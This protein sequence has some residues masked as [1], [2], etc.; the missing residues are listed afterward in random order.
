M[1]PLTFKMPTK[2]WDVPMPI[3]FESCECCSALW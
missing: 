1:G 3:V 2:R